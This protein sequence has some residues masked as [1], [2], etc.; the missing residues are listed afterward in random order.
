MVAQE[1]E[2]IHYVDVCSLYP[3]ILK[4]GMFPEGHPQVLSDLNPGDFT[5]QALEGQIKDMGHE[6]VRGIIQ[7][8]VPI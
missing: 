1:D 7:A 8:K 6:K 3:H 2:E 5:I 4:R